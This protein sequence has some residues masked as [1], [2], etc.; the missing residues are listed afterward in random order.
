MA[1]LLLCALPVVAGQCPAGFTKCESLGQIC[2]NRS[3]CLGLRTRCGAGSVCA[4]TESRCGAESLCSGL[5]SV[6]GKFSECSGLG[7][8]CDEP[9]PSPPEPMP[10]M[11]PMEPMQPMKPMPT[12]KPMEP[13]PTM[14][15]MEPMKPSHPLRPVPQPPAKVLN[16][17]CG[18]GSACSGRGASSIDGMDVCCRTDCPMCSISAS[19]VNG[20][21]STTCVCDYLL[22]SNDEAQPQIASLRATVDPGEEA[23]AVQ[24]EG[25]DVGDACGSR[26]SSMVDGHRFCCPADCADCGVSVSKSAT[27]ISANCVCAVKGWTT[28]Q[29]CAAVAGVAL[30]LG[31]GVYF[32]HKRQS[33]ELSEKLLQ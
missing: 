29:K 19:S 18:L 13:L 14:K 3:C 2:G 20:V 9:Q 26:G 33:P 4:G 25:C 6:C 7:A 16:N 8:L 22:V 24:N 15:P 30:M 28:A 10:T 17:G 31:A 32:L 21:L 12:M 11:R 1:R 23:P 5:D 27:S